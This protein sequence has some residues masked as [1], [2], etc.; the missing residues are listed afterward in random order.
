[1]KEKGRGCITP[2][3]WSSPFG[4]LT[5]PCSL[6]WLWQAKRFRFWLQ[7]KHSEALW[8]PCCLV[9]LAIGVLKGP[10]CHQQSVARLQ[11]ENRAEM[12][13]HTCTS[14][15]KHIHSFIVFPPIFFILLPEWNRKYWCE[16]SDRL[17]STDSCSNH[18]SSGGL[19]SSCYHCYGSLNPSEES[20]FMNDWY[21]CVCGVMLF[22]WMNSVLHRF[23]NGFNCTFWS[24]IVV[25]SLFHPSQALMEGC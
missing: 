19:K 14:E 3:D 23:H 7:F 12:W 9:L 10:R 2:H 21:Q 15:K 13:M 18:L 5:L 22:N 16:L 6:S 20:W 11:S 1:M 4:Q 25:S 17:T 24:R 8:K